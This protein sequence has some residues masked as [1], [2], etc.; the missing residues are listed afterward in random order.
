MTIAPASEAPTIAP[1][2]VLRRI[3]S[4]P[5][6]GDAVDAEMPAT[7][8]GSYQEARLALDVEVS[9]GLSDI[10]VQWRGSNDPNPDPTVDADWADI[11]AEESLTSFTTGQ[12]TVSAWTDVTGYQYVSPRVWHSGSAGAARFVVNIQRAR[13][14]GPA[15]STGPAGA[16]G[17]A[18]PA[19]PTGATGATGAQGDAGATGA[20]GPAGP[21]GATGP[22]GPTGA[23]G[24]GVTAGGSEGHVFLRGSVDQT[25]EPT[26]PN[27]FMGDTAN[28]PY[29]FAWYR[30]LLSDPVNLI[31]AGGLTNLTG[32]TN[33]KS[34]AIPNLAGDV[35][36]VRGTVQ[37]EML[38]AG[39]VPTL[40]CNVT[41]GTGTCM[42]RVD[43]PDGSGGVERV[44]SLGSG[45]APTVSCVSTS[46]PGVGQYLVPFEIMFHTITVAISFQLQG[47]ASVGN[48]DAD[49]GWLEQGLFGDPA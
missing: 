32:L 28:G 11:G 12:T 44:E 49:F 15:G 8:M 45:A 19:G 43:F 24:V 40:A 5:T 29:K 10:N 18:G 27:T 23:A 38:A 39:S 33:P 46:A 16:T 34:V 4:P 37:M 20:T 31:A 3:Q 25:A 30:D 47:A 26:D 9:T 14:T 13:R 6:S 41:G 22:A 42:M 17:P 1:S 36:V 48:I 21:T 2:R 35:W 7:A